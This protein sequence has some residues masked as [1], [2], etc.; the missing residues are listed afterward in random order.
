MLRTSDSALFIKCTQIST[1]FMR[2]DE[3]LDNGDVIINAIRIKSI[4][5]QY[6]GTCRICFSETDYLDVRLKGD[7]KKFIGDV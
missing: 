2:D 4:L 7:I 6:E 5:F 1:S 3:F